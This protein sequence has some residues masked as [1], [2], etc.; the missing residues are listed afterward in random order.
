MLRIL[1]SG[2]GLQEYTLVNADYTALVPEGVEDEDAGSWPVDA[3]TVS[4]AL[5]SSG[6]LGG[7][8]LKQRS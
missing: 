7:V 5:F 8:S 2:G 3:V 4:M 1:P 6:V